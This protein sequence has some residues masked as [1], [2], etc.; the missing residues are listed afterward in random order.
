MYTGTCELLKRRPPPFLTILVHD[1]S[2]GY[3]LLKAPTPYVEK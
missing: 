1:L 3:P 2:I